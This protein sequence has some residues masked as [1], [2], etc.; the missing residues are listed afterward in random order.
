MR[1]FIRHFLLFAL[2]ISLLTGCRSSQESWSISYDP[3]GATTESKPLSE[4]H[5]RTI[6]IQSQGVWVSNEFDGGR[7][8]DF[9][10]IDE[11][12][13]RME[14]HPE[15]APINR[16]AWYSFKVWSD[17]PKTIEIEL[18]YRDGGHRYIPKFSTDA[19]SWTMADST[20][21]VHNR[22]TE[23]ALVTI[24][25]S[26]D[27]L[28]V[29]AQEL[30]TSIHVEAWLDSLSS[31]PGTQISTVGKS[32]LGKPLQRLTINETGLE[33]APAIIITGRQHP[34]EVTGS[35]GQRLFI[36]TILSDHPIAREFRQRFQVLAY[37][38]MNRD[39]VDAGHW[40]H[41]AGGVDLNRDWGPFNQPENSAVRDDLLN[42]KSRG[43]EVWYTLD[44]HSTSYDVFYT[45]NKDIP[46][47]I[48]GLTDRWLMGITNRIPDYTIREEPSGVAA[49]IAKNWFYKTFDQ[50]DGVTYEVG[51]AIPRDRIYEVVQAAALSL[52]EQLL[53]SV[54][55]QYGARDIS[56]QWQ[57]QLAHNGYEVQLDRYHLQF[58]REHP[59][60]VNSTDFITDFSPMRMRIHEFLGLSLVPTPSNLACSKRDLDEAVIASVSLHTRQREAM[61][62]IYTTIRDTFGSLWPYPAL[63]VVPHVC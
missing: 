56:H 42:W 54:P 30:F 45:I 49:P 23:S 29:S 28:W 11:N 22:E 41:N 13:F 14:I 59:L 48:P 47:K 43:L 62:H 24:H 55:S 39:G 7:L 60:L 36:E 4:H 32:T 18:V 52:M 34:P 38:L 44:F 61:D 5:R 58:Q 63:G 2:G 53:S 37:P 17:S 31:A 27:T 50:A 46:V 21:Y 15:N 1:L 10:A 19:Y 40:R 9:Y 26:P 20:Q 33:L 51:D 16:S 25:V 35:I 12:R 8:N 57:L 6:G 3:P